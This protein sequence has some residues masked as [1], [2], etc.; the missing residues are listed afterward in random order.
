M[1]SN[2]DLPYKEY[3]KL[4][5]LILLFLREKYKNTIQAPGALNCLKIYISITVWVKSEVLKGLKIFNV[6]IHKVYIKYWFISSN[7]AKAERG[8]VIKF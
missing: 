8:I 6:F 2:T 3:K 4:L 1:K 7:A 5:H